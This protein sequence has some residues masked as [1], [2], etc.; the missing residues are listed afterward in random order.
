MDGK[1]VYACNIC[2]EGLDSVEEVRNH[3]R[4]THREVVSHIISDGKIDEFKNDK[5]RENKS[6]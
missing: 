2:D 4:D 6:A 3:V 5:C 1:K